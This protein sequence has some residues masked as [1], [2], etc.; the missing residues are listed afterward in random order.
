[1][2]KKKIKI[3]KIVL[4]IV[5]I[6]LLIFLVK[7]TRNMIILKKIDNAVSKY[8]NSNNVHIT[9]YTYYGDSLNITESYKKDD[10]YLVK[11]NADSK[12]HKR[13]LINYCDGEKVNTYIESDS[14]KIAILNSNALPSAG[15]VANYAENNSL[16]EFLV[17]SFC[18]SIKSEVCNGK[19][20]YKLS[21]LLS[22][23][24]FIVSNDEDFSKSDF[25]IYIDKETGLLVRQFNG[26]SGEG[27]D[28]INTVNDMKYE[29]DTV[30]DADIV[31]PDISEYTI[32]ENN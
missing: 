26:T 8:Q 27:K 18:T 10:K 22:S 29:F 16:W 9:S 14:D 13:R 21:N 32:Q 1:M 15:Q 23:S 4:I 12:D 20:C 19:D 6:I 25:S 7:T 11:V 24:V 31:E 30:T 28:K 17:M 2:E 3:W 5:G